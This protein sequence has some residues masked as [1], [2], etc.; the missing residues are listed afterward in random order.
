M[1][2][3]D[4]QAK[5]IRSLSYA[6]AMRPLGLLLEMRDLKTFDL[7]IDNR[8]FRLMCGYQKPP[9]S[10]TVELRYSVDEIESLEREN[11]IKR[12]DPR[13]QV[14]FLSLTGLLRGLG[15]YVD[16]KK[17]HLIRISN[18]DSNLAGGS[19]KL[20]YKSSDGH[21]Q[22]EIF[23]L[24][25]IYDICVRMYRERGKTTSPASLFQDS[26]R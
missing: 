22:A 11:L 25:S 26:R 24:S 1:F 8:E 20:E 4:A 21:L 15:G 23:S 14:D 7:K 2:K 13:K 19:V 17:G 16:K 18:N 9:C 3:F 12:N 10:P 5:N 6:R